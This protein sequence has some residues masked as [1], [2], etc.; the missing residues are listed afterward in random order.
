MAARITTP[1]PERDLTFTFINTLD[2]PFFS[3]LVGHASASFSEVVMAGCRIENAISIGKL[4]VEKKPSTS[5]MSPYKAK[6]A[7]VSVVNVA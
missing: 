2:E 1:L 3:H 6:D 7:T 5:K 4:Q